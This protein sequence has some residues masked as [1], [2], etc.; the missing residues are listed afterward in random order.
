MPGR[1]RLAMLALAVMACTPTVRVETPHPTVTMSQDSLRDAEIWRFSLSE[2]E[3]EAR[4]GQA[5]LMLGASIV[6]PRSPSDPPAAQL[7]LA[8]VDLLS[9]TAY[10]EPSPLAFGDPVML[11]LPGDTLT[12]GTTTL[13]AVHPSGE[14]VLYTSPVPIDLEDFAAV[15]SADSVSGRIGSQ[16]RPASTLRMARH[17]LEGMRELFLR[18]GAAEWLEHSRAIRSVNAGRY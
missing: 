2:V 17:H 13:G 4:N 6:V 1:I 15:A 8:A 3:A 10:D 14:T 7:D 16:Y 12:V 5:R 18:S 11:F 9:I